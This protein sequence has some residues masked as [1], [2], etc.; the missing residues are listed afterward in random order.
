[1]IYFE[2]PIFVSLSFDNPTSAS[3]MSQ[4]SKTRFF[5]FKN[6]SIGDL[7]FSWEALKGLR[8]FQYDKASIVPEGR[9]NHALSKDFFG[10][11]L[12]E[13]KSQE[14]CQKALEYIRELGIKSAGVDFSDTSDRVKV[15]W[16]VDGLVAEGVGVLLHLVQS[17][18]YAEQMPKESAC[19]QWRT[20]V[21]ESLNHYTGKIEAVEIGNTINRAKWSGYSLGGFQALWNIAYS[22]V[23]DHGLTLVGPNVT[24]FEPQ[25]NAGLL[26][27][28]AKR[29]Q[30]PD[31]HSNNLFAERAGE[32]EALDHKI[33]GRM[34][35]A[36]LSYNLRKKIWLIASIASRNCMQRNWSTCSF[37]TLPR[38][39]RIW[40]NPEEKMADYLVRHQ[41]ITA[42]SMQF[43]RN[44]WG[45]LISY[46]E[47]LIDDGTNDRSL[48]DGRD[49]VSF[50]DCLLGESSQWRARPAFEALKTLISQLGNSH[51]V[52]ASCV[53]RQLEI[54]QFTKDGR[55]VYVAWTSNGRVARFKD[56]FDES[57][58]HQ[59]QHVVGRDGQVMAEI[60]DFFRGSPIYVITKTEDISLARESIQL[61]GQVVAARPAKEQAYYDF[62]TDSWRGMVM[63]NSR[64]DAELLMDALQ[65]DMIKQQ[66]DIGTLRN[67]RNVIWKVSDPRDPQRSLVVK[68][69]STM[70]WHKRI[71]DRN[72]P[73]KGLRSWNGTAEIMRRGIETPKTVAY[74]ESKDPSDLMNNWFIC[75]F[76]GGGLSVRNFWSAYAQGE[77]QLHGYTFEAF[78][79][80]LIEFTITMHRRGIFF[81]DLSGGNVL[82]EIGA[83]N[84]LKFS[85]IDTARARCTSWGV[86]VPD[87]VSDLKRLVLKLQPKQQA[88]F[89][90]KYMSRLGARFS[91]RYRLTFKLYAVKTDLK[92]FKR[93]VIRKLR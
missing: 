51:Y 33:L 11:C 2:V 55:S 63:A 80:E 65:P 54:H 71:L 52:G 44:Y 6:P 21:K 29:D 13:P 40:G 73:S 87:R 12:A 48:S 85:L 43:E 69:P 23:K 22:I 66:E 76:M 37:W 79:D 49:I 60:P 9:Q 61:P 90:D 78:V 27:T 28:L 86:C 81:R 82:V 20:F 77:S 57:N 75:E 50:Y 39:N 19:L 42:T 45:P 36:V 56:C 4:T 93:R 53:N 38:L 41:L 58:F 31:V 89:I 5:N 72:K 47:G 25:Y 15:D 26:A 74:F 59:I 8:P 67:S 24:D 88:Y 35:R 70:A 7:E 17:L 30:L 68:K 18:E 83:G 32:P 46:R 62:E 84:E 34:F 64:G 14:D 10:V 3:L 16:L 1:M 91:M 92:R